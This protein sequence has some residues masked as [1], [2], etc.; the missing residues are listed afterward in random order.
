[1]N[2]ERL[3]RQLVIDEGKREAPYKDSVGIWTI[4]IGRNMA[5]GLTAQEFTSLCM[6]VPLDES[7]IDYLFRRDFETHL[8]ETR[9]LFPLLESYAP[10]RQEALV[11][12][13]FN[14]GPAKLA[15]FSKMRAEI[16]CDD[17][18]MAA[19]EAMDSVWYIQVGMRGERIVYA[20]R[21]GEWANPA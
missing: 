8:Q 2:I 14:L 21:Y 10:A 7:Q 15:K 12:M 20:L 3:K 6:L 4:G 13:C 1:M 5:R 16:D 19:D 9:K 18:N 11:N 17:W